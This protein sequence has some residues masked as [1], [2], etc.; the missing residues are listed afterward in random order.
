MSTATV[1]QPVPGYD[2][3]KTKN[4][5]ASLSSRSQ[6]ELAEI[7]SYERA[8]EN[9]R[10]VFDK[11]RWLRQD[12]PLPGYDALSSEE[13]VAML[14]EADVTTIKRVRGYERKFAARRVVLDEV[15]R[16]HRKR[17]LPLVSRDTNR[18]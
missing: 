16:L 8:H 2:G 9:R 18:R 11:L 6:V 13:V 3:L 15:T 10:V 12:E 5:V 1:K 14:D 4:V 7:E 17:R